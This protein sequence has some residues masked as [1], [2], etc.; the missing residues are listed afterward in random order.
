MVSPY[1]PKKAV[2]WHVYS[3]TSVALAGLFVVANM[4]EAGSTPQ[5]VG[6]TVAGLIGAAIMAFQWRTVDVAL[7]QVL[8]GLS[9][10]VIALVVFSH[11]FLFNRPGVAV[12]M[13]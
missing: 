12:R 9:A 3:G 13:N 2:S 10:L 11:F 1:Q 5:G 8:I 6:F 4:T 7:H